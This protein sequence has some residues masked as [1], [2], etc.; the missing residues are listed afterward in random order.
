MGGF[1][2]NPS[3]RLAFAA[4]ILV[5]GGLGQVH[6]GAIQGQTTGST[7]SEPALA[8]HPLSRDDYDTT[9]TFNITSLS[10]SAIITQAANPF[11]P[12]YNFVFAGV[13]AIGRNFTPIDPSD[14]NI[15][16]Y[17]PWVVTDPGIDGEDGVTFDRGVTDQ[18]AGGGSI[19]LTYTP[20]AATDP[21]KVNFLQAFSDQSNGLG[22]P[23]SA[24]IMD[25]GGG[26][27]P[28]YNQKGVSGTDG[29][30]VHPVPLDATG[31]T[32][33]MLDDSYDCESG[34]NGTG[35][36][37]PATTA[38]NDETKTFSKVVFDTFIEGDAMFGGKNYMVLYGGFQW[39]YK[40]AAFDVPEPSTWAMLALGFAGL[41]AVGYYR[42]APK[43]A[44]VVTIA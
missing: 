31:T 22:G 42:R 16:D 23:M 17:F 9:T 11:K 25:N 13:G 20:T 19:V 26:P 10:T 24:I 4:G 12:A 8:K 14:F 28:Y 21:T 27:V 34:S 30:G 15:V 44:A 3:I 36:G 41:G 37:C 38:A 35:M 18:D 39:G 2:S 5:A 7:E 43:A 6:A 33:W 40:F 1:L 29:N 32:A